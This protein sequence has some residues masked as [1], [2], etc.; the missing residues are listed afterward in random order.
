[1]FKEFL[2]ELV[3]KSLGLQPHG[4]IKDL[5]VPHLLNDE[6][7]GWYGTLTQ[8]KLAILDL[9][10]VTRPSRNPQQKH[11]QKMGNTIDTI[12][13]I[14]YGT[15]FEATERCLKMA[16]QSRVIPIRILMYIHTNIGKT[17]FGLD[18]VVIWSEGPSNFPIL[19][20]KPL[21]YG[22]NVSVN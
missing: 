14:F 16:N 8:R 17:S 12:P 15:K 21:L 5:E 20:E 1:M 6:E 9:F 3:P 11:S 7:N 18:H 22:A 19:L 2:F 10:T 13:S 4:P